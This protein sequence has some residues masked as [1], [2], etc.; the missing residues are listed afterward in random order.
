MVI[1]VSTV[2]SRKA[3]REVYNAHLDQ[4]NLIARFNWKDAEF[5]TELDMRH[6]HFKT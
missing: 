4:Y 3:G 1:H 5:V 6:S 2:R